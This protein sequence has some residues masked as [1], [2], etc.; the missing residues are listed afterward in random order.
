[1]NWNISA[2]ILIVATFTA[3][4]SQAWVYFVHI[5]VSPCGSDRYTG[6]SERYP[7]KTIPRALGYINSAD[8]RDKNIVIELMC[9]TCGDTCYFDLKSTLVITNT[10]KRT[11]TIRA[12][13]A[14]NVRITGGARIPWYA[15]KPVTDSVNLQDVAKRN[16]L[17]VHLPD[18]GITDLGEIST[19]GYYFRRTSFL[20]IFENDK[21]GRLAR[22][23]NEG[24]IN[25]DTPGADYKSFTYVSDRPKTWQ[26]ETDIWVHGFWYWGWADRSYKVTEL[27]AEKNSLAVSDRVMY[28]I[29]KGHYNHANP[30]EGGYHKQGGHFRFLNVLYELDSPGEF[31]VDRINQILYVW[32]Y[33]NSKYVFGDVIQTS[34]ID[35][36]IKIS[37]YSS[38]ILLKGFTIEACR[39]HGIEAKRVENV[40]FSELTIQNLGSYGIVADGKQVKIDRCEIKNTDGGID[41]SGGIRETL[42]PSG[43][44]ISNNVISNFGRVGYVGSDGVNLRGVGIHI[45]HNT[46]DTGSYTGIHWAGND[47]TFEYNHL[48]KMCTTASDC[49][50]F[51]AGR[52]WTWRGNQIRSNHIHGTKSTIP[53]ADVRGIM[54]DDQLSGIHIEHN[55]F[56]NND[57]HCNIGGGRDNIVRSNI[58]YNA[59]KYSMQFDSRGKFGGGH[60]LGTLTA[61]LK[62]VPYEDK[63][64]SE[65]YP[66]LASIL[67]ST[68]S[69]GNP[70]NNIIV[71]NVF[72][73]KHI[74]AIDGNKYGS[75]WFL[76]ADNI[77]TSVNENFVAPVYGNFRLTCSLKDVKISAPVT[78]NEVGPRDTVGPIAIRH[79]SAAPGF[80]VGTPRT[81][82]TCPQ[83]LPPVKPPRELYLSDGSAPNRI[84][85]DVPKQGCWFRFE[86]CPN[87]VQ[88]ISIP[89]RPYYRY[90]TNDGAETNE[91]ICLDLTTK[92]MQECGN[93]A[94]FSIIYGPTGAMTVGGEGCFF[95]W[96][97]CPRVGLYRSRIERDNWAERHVNGAYD[98]KACLNRAFPQWRYCGLNTSYPV[99]S[100]FK[101]T[102]HFKVS[103]GGCY[104]KPDKCPGNSSLER[105]FY[106]GDGAANYGTDDMMESCF[107]RA[108]YFWKQC[109]SDLRYPVTAFFRPEGKSS[110]YPR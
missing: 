38:N 18:V 48:Y 69:P 71:N 56:V 17:Q 109:G 83:S 94:E 55:V 52:E 60:T 87:H 73:S 35:T 25:I 98:E 64:W 92:M 9:G 110:R 59:S 72:Y 24:Y 6:A 30:T 68:S 65:R 96:Y 26:N 70:E 13:K 103:G 31:Y 62:R 2:F 82:I 54:L 80:A 97:G 4:N 85:S 40:E 84:Y 43:H 86:M 49:G 1:M 67:N 16:V 29:R 88:R 3:H 41:I 78:A 19:F 32:P 100:I 27:D 8:N 22:Y 33:K 93:G 81:Q 15:F 11:L 66:E 91:T 63:L 10:G 5:Y 46:F 101:P 89:S 37:D 106:D 76:V 74:K 45:H 39:K 7:L 107:E 75:N 79:M 21:P 20:E 102:G 105:M 104:I 90:E 57:V 51:M 34:I 50:A 12:Y 108:E 61:L 95:A 23:P 14:D 58:F 99:V 42:T 44:V 77:Y 53:G 36:C 47:H 28:G